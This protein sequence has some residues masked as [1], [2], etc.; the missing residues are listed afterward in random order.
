MKI[1]GIGGVFWR[2][3]DIKALKKWYKETLFI[4]FGDWNGTVIKPHSDN[5]TIFSLFDHD[6]EYFPKE[7]SV[8]LNFQVDNISEWVK[9]F[10]KI[11]VKLLKEPVMSE[12]GAF[13]W[14]ADPEG[15]WIELWE[16]K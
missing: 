3:Q 6:N 10:N 11:G 1:N 8:M 2:T 4:S 5:G 9:H 13:V 7:Q 15:R 12:Y 14:I 16:K